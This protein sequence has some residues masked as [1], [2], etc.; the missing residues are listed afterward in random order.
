MYNKQQHL[1][2]IG[3]GGVGMAGIA[4]VLHNLGYSVSGSDLRGNALTEA[5]QRLGAEVS[6]GHKQENLSEQTEVVV[7]SSAISETN[8]ELQA[9]RRRKIPVIPRAEMLSE[10]MRMKYGIAVAGSHGKT[11]TTSMC[12]K[13]LNDLGLDPTVIV[14]GRVLSQATGASVGQGDYLVAE[15]DES[16]GSFCLLKPAIAIVTNIDIEHL[17][18]YGSFGALEDAFAHFMQSVPF[19]GLVVANADDP[20]VHRLA[21]SLTR[22]CRFY[23]LTNSSEVAARNSTADGP[24]YKFDLHLEGKRTTEIRLP[25]SGTHMVSNSLAAITVALELGGYPDEIAA[26]LATFPGVARRC[27]IIVSAEQEVMVIDDYGH[28]PTEIRAT[29][30][31][32]REGWLPHLAK[33]QGLNSPGRLIVLFEPHRYSRTKELFSEFVTAFADADVVRVGDIYAAGEEPMPGVSAEHL[34]KSLQHPDARFCGD[35]QEWLKELVPELNRGD[36]VL[37]LGAG[38]IGKVAHELGAVL[39]A[40]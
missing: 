24:H 38:N 28:H 10:L 1:H 9:A 7:V 23:G 13:L 4:E 35:L 18:H 5:L 27:E 12:A 32:V 26:S 39:A 17:S 19:Y 40:R 14:G 29:I 16:D 11:T 2:F 3:I 36:I 37:T 21:S 6:I 22:R 31:A 8:P 33:E 20:V 15:A 30:R 25:M 34:V